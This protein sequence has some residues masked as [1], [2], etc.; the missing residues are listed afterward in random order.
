MLKSQMLKKINVIILYFLFTI[1]LHAQ[2]PFLAILDSVF[3]NTTQEFRA[4]EYS[5]YCKP[6]GVLTL[7]MF[8]NNANLDATCRNKIDKFYINHP[9]LKNY[10]LILL[11]LEQRYHIEFKDTKCILY[12]KGQYTLSELLLKEGLALIKPSFMDDE[13]RYSFF[14]AQKKAK[15]EKKG[16]WKEKGLYGCIMKVYND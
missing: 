9:Y 5:F 2:E 1:P 10:S 6:Y 13:F 7:D 14:K 11:E 12:A 3:S 4:G 8:L 16:L 15:I